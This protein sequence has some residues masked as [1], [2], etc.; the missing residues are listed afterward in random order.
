MEQATVHGG[1]LTARAVI[2]GIAQVVLVA[3]SVAGVAALVHRCGP[4]VSLAWLVVLAGLGWT[5]AALRAAVTGE[6]QRG[7]VRDAAW[8]AT[9]FLV[10]S[11]L[12]ATSPDLYARLLAV[13]A[14]L[15]VVGLRLTARA[16]PQRPALPAGQVARPASAARAAGE[17]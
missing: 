2:G 7:A 1:A 13:L 15:V 8:W 14:A 3:G 11:T 12:A 4:L 9:T 5:A 17:V 16:E 10:A 6:R